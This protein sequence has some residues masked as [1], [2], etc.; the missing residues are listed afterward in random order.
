MGI[1]KDIF[2]MKNVNLILTVMKNKKQYDNES[3]IDSKTTDTKTGNRK[4]RLI[5]IC[6][7]TK[8]SFDIDSA[9]CQLLMIL[10]QPQHTLVNSL[11]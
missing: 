1:T 9:S 8:K 5:I 10:F 2:Q 3:T 7:L 4:K 11:N 6:Q